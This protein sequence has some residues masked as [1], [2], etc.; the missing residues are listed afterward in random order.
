LQTPHIFVPADVEHFSLLWDDIKL[1]FDF[2]PANIYRKQVHNYIARILAFSNHG[3]LM[4]QNGT[5]RARKCRRIVHSGS[6]CTPFDQNQKLVR[7]NI[8]LRFLEAE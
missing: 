3:L 4:F 6:T 7:V 2:D 8:D 5:P 1:Q